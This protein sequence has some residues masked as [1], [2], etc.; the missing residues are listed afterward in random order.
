MG[1][2]R[3]FL[4]EQWVLES[5]E[6]RI[7][8]IVGEQRARA[9]E[10]KAGRRVRP[11]RLGV[12]A[13]RP[14]RGQAGRNQLPGCRRSKPIPSKPS[15]DAMLTLLDKLKVIET[16]GVLGV[17]LLWLNGNYQR[18]LFHFHQV[19][20]PSGIRLLELAEATSPSGVGLLSLAELPRRR[21]SH[22][23]R[24]STSY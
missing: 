9:R 4:K 13:R 1:R 7:A 15:V 5:A 17:D 12:F 23:S 20:K 14:A 6:F 18:T 11:E 22:R 24:C 2:A 8:R 21:R 10:L 3:E 16:T 19:R